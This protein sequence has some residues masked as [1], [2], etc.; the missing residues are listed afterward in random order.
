MDILRRISNS[1]QGVQWSQSWCR[2]VAGEVLRDTPPHFPP[3]GAFGVSF[4]A[5]SAP[6]SRPPKLIGWLRACGDRLQLDR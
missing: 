6:R 3:L 1:P 5:P 2:P 4:S